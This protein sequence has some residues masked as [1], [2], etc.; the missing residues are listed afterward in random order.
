MNNYKIDIEL[1]DGVYTMAFDMNAFATM[2]DEFEKPM[3]EIKDSE[4]FSTARAKDV[5]RLFYIFLKSNHPELTKEDVG[6]L[7]HIGNVQDIIE[8]M[9]ALYKGTHPQNNGQQKKNTK[10]NVKSSM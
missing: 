4:L 8:K 1:A 7:I 5:I 9:E 6:R 3:S 2:E 10:K